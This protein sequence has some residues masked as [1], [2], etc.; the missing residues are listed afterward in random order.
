MQFFVGIEQNFEENESWKL[1]IVNS[2]YHITFFY[3][4]GGQMFEEN[5]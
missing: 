4:K 2:L 5:W 1:R 3:Q